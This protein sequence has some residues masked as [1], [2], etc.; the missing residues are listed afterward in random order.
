MRKVF[1]DMDGV[2]ARFEEQP[3]AV[4]RFAV[5]RG[6]F[7]NLEPTNLVARLVKHGVPNNA[8][9]LTASPHE[10]AD[11]DKIEWIKEHLPQLANRVVIVRNG[12]DKAK[13]AEGNLLLDDYTNNLEYWVENGGIG[14]KAL[15][16]FNGT[17][18]RHWK[19]VAGTLV[20]D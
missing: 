7:R 4:E 20:V 11:N 18:D 15:N 14:I 19:V 17:T 1:F 8:Y 2:L 13:Y 3:N 5:E 12:K 6:F 9:V 10:Q 16:K